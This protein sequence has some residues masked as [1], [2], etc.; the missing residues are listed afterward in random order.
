MSYSFECKSDI[1]SFINESSLDENKKVQ[2]LEKIEEQS[3]LYLK[4]KIS[5]IEQV[6]LPDIEEKIKAKINR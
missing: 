2:L 5:L 4:S 6:K 3:K 1:E